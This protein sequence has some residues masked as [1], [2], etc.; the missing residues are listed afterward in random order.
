[1]L[2]PSIERCRSTLKEAKEF[3]EKYDNTPEAERYWNITEVEK[4]RERYWTE[5]AWIDDK[6][7][8]QNAMKCHQGVILSVD[9]MA[10]RFI[11]YSMELSGLTMQKPPQKEPEPKEEPKGDKEKP[12]E[13]KK[14]SKEEKKEEEKEKGEEGEKVKHDEL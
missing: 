11:D 4:I 5:L 8:K 13:D 10:K 12:E 7:A 3:F 1:M 6:E 2:P 9:E 14:E